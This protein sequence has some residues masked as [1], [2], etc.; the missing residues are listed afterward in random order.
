MGWSEQAATR[1]GKTTINSRLNIKNKTTTE[2]LLFKDSKEL[3]KS[4]QI[5]ERRISLGNF[6]GPLGNGFGVDDVPIYKAFSQ[7]VHTSQFCVIANTPEEHPQ[8]L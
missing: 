6:P 1:P 2:P 4:R 3:N 8:S 5:L 7:N